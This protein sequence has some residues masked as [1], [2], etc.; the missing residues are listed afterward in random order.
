M[1]TLPRMRGWGLWAGALSLSVLGCAYPNH[2]YDR[3]V[4]DDVPAEGSGLSNALFQSVGVELTP[5]NEVKLV[6]NGAIFDDVVTEISKAKQSVNIELFIWRKC[7]PSDR[8]VA[9]IQERAKHG[10]A[11]HVV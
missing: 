3:K 1:A 7:D 11:C 6:Q 2:R 5:G 8:I 9:A 4:R 10:V